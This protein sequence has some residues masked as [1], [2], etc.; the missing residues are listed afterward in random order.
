M[1]NNIFACHSLK[2]ILSS[3]RVWTILFN[4]KDKDL[5]WLCAPKAMMAALANERWKLEDKYS[6]PRTAGHLA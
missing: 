4:G 1:E 5:K 2:T 6:G 3:S